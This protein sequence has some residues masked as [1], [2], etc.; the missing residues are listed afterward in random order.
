M[1]AAQVLSIVLGML[2]AAPSAA[3]DT[4][5]TP[6]PLLEINSV[7]EEWSPFLSDDGLTLYFARVRGPIGFYG[8]IWEANRSICLPSCL[9]MP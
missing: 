1:R 3:A 2:L 4:W 9:S 6:Q 5:T 7:A 8:R